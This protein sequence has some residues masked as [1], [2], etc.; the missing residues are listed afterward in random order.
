MDQVRQ[1]DPGAGHPPHDQEV[2]RCEH[3]EMHREWRKFRVVNIL[4]QQM[5]ALVV[6]EVV[7]PQDV[8]CRVQVRGLLGCELRPL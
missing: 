2:Q 5:S 3:I 1:G 6:F 8:S 7:T 4:N